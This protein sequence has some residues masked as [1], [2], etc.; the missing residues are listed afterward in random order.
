MM[1]ERTDARL[2]MSCLVYRMKK[3]AR[4]NSFHAMYY[5]SFNEKLIM[6]QTLVLLTVLAVKRSME[7]NIQARAKQ[8]FTQI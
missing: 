6:F 2:L 5:R 7:R 1:H 3:Y 8:R 4:Q